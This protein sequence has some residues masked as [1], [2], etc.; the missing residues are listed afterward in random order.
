MLLIDKL[1]SNII[2][3]FFYSCLKLEFIDYYYLFQEREIQ[4]LSAEIESLKNPQNLSPSTRLD[5]LREENAKLKYRLNILKRV[6]HMA[7]CVTVEIRMYFTTLLPPHVSL[8]TGS[9][10][11]SDVLQ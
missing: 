3:I 9:T 6:R 5:E 11:G 10:G 1:C 4:S 2:S 8:S 7:L